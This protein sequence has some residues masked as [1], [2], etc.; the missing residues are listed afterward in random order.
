MIGNT[1]KQEFIDGLIDDLTDASSPPEQ[2]AGIQNMATKLVARIE[3]LIKAGQ[4]TI[5][6]DATGTTTQNIQ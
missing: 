3:T 5:N 6:L 4:V 2:I 1:E